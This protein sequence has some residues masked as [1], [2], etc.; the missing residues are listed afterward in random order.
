MSNRP[1]LGLLLALATVLPGAT[2]AAVLEGV[3]LSVSG[4][5]IERAWIGTDDG[6]AETYTDGTGRFRLSEVEPPVALVVSH[7]RYETSTLPVERETSDL[8]L[9]LEPKRTVYEEIVVSADRGAR[10]VAPTSVAVATESPDDLPAPPSTLTETVERIPGVA[11]NGQGGIFQTYSIRGVA[12]QRILTLMAGVPVIGER[13]AG[14]SA[15]FIDP[16]LMETVEVVRGPSSTYYGSG[17]LGGVVQVLP[18]VYGASVAR[19]AYDSVGDEHVVAAGWGDERWS[20]GLAH[21]QADDAETPGGERLNSHFEQTSASLSRSWSTTEGELELA[22]MPSY[23]S[24]IGKV[25]T[26]FPEEVTTYPRER[27]LVTRLRYEGRGGWRASLFAHPNDLVT[28][29]VA[30]P[31]VNEVENEAFDYGATLQ[32]EIVWLEGVSLQTGVDYLARRGVTAHEERFR[33]EGDGTV[34]LDEITTLDDA[35]RDDVALFAATRLGISEA[36]LTIGARYTWQRQTNRGAATIEDGAWNGF[37]GGVLPLGESYE[38]S[39]NVGTGFRF[40]S[41]SE[42]YFTGTT[43][44][45]EV[46]GNA[47]LSPERSLNAD[48]GV[49]RYGERLF[50][51]LYLFRNEIDDYVERIEVAP[52]VLTFVNLTSG[53]IEGI[54]LDGLYEL[55]SHWRLAFS[56]HSIEGES[57]RG[58]PLADI[59]ADRAT[60]GAIWQRGPWQIEGR[61]QRR[62]EKEDPGSGERA[63]PAADLVSV[64]VSREV[65]PA[66]GLTVTGTNLL[67]ESYFSAADDKLPPAPGRG[68]GIGLRWSAE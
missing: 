55:S 10:R 66:L 60:V 27:H 49:R 32:R 24:D 7:P 26:D 43:G 64:A 39:A 2:G 59:P 44:R 30:G 12:R 33:R 22:L 52:D 53:T 68:F 61:Y 41:L 3:V 16:L 23:A 47:D 57:E 62:A 35:E 1:A 28:R 36:T 18:R 65:S 4:V 25:N 5:P 51:A 13:R 45:G 38:L 17:A 67:D 8:E 63:I 48:L 40:P 9:R 46:V 31:R 37:L 29:D 14:V 50:L 54:E 6:A 11:E 42:R 34:L 58:A 56:A 15:S 20:L 19:A 21:R